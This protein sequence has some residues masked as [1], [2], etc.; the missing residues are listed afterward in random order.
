MKKFNTHFLAI[1][2]VLSILLLSCQQKP[3]QVFTQ[4]VEQ[5]IQLDS[6]ILSVSV[7]TDSLL[8]PWELVWGPDNFIW[9]SEE[10]GTIHR[11][12]P[13][14]GEKHL[15][16]QLP[17]GKRPEGLQSFIVHPDQ[18]KYPY[19][20]LNYKKFDKDS[21]RYNIV[22][23][24]TYQNDTLIQPKIIIQDKAGRSH[25]GA[26]LAFHGSEHILWA[27][28]D[29]YVN[30]NP[31]DVDNINGKVLRMDLDGNVPSDNP[32]PKS[33]VYA[34]GFR[35]MQGLAVTPEGTIYIS[36]HGDATEDE[37]N[38]IQPGG[39]YGYP[40]IEGIIDND[41]ER[42]FEKEHRT[43]PPLM[44]WTPTIAPAGMEYY[45]IQRNQV[46]IPEWNNALLLVMLKGQGLR[47]LNLNDE[48]TEVVRE[49]IFLEKLYGRIRAICVSPTGDVY[50][51]T[52][53]HDWNPMTEPAER[54]DRIL[55]IAKVDQALK[56]P[57]RAKTMKEST[58]ELA[59]GETLYQQ[60]CFSCH[61]AKG[62]GL[63]GIYPALAAS[64]IV[65][66]EEQLIETV[67]NGRAT[68]QYDFAMPA[69]AFLDDNELSKILNYVRT[70]FGNKLDSIEVRN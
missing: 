31:Q 1:I 42:A 53:N 59:T 70:S 16:L 27:T 14:T 69:F 46:S 63:D 25:T 12:N 29:Q 39:N 32:F 3:K 15:V 20:Y 67:K 8:V 43:V 54:D 60:Y 6:T 7:I 23:R 9:V 55:R 11:V 66:D 65:A 10:R 30:S 48:G 57:L 33:Y 41:L 49:E 56:T 64:D 52:S 4:E 17:I 40:N 68:G 38:L 24:Y 28:G 47:V 5:N 51:S 36:E 2:T 62:E 22:E 35:N 58:H 34:L 37:I 13:E 44:A 19:V 50:I 26:R 18:K 21:I 61:K 45:P